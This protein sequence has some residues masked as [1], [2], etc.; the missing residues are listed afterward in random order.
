M[1]SH[2]QLSLIWATHPCSNYNSQACSAPWVQTKNIQQ[3]FEWIKSLALFILGLW[4]ISTV[5]FGSVVVSIQQNKLERLP[6]AKIFSLKFVSMAGASLWMIVVYCGARSFN[7]LDISSTHRFV[8]LPFCQLVN[9]PTCHFVNLP[10]HL[11][12]VLSTCHLV[13]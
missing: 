1:Y 10:F 3:V 6:Y 5:Y 11:L 12:P 9:L 2:N 13:N 7:Q 8:N 4:I